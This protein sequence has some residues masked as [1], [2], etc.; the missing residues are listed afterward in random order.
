MKKNIKKILMLWLLVVTWLSAFNTTALADDNCNRY[1]AKC[2]VEDI[3]TFH[4]DDRT[5]TA[6]LLDTVKNAINRILWLLATITLCICLYGW[7]KMLSS[8]TDSKWYD[9]WWKVLKNALIWLAIILLAWM[10]V[11]VVFWFVSNV[12]DSNH[13]NSDTQQP[14]ATDATS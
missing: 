14:V 9:A 6:G 4:T 3:D 11:S 1:W 10:I 13:T 12:S 5:V 8:W 7:F 2:H